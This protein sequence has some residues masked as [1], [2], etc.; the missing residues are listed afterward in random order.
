MHQ[1]KF[2]NLQNYYVPCSDCFA[3]EWPTRSNIF[4]CQI[5]FNRYYTSSLTFLYY[6]FNISVIE[7]HFKLLM[8]INICTIHLDVFFLNSLKWCSSLQETCRQSVL[9][10]LTGSYIY[11]QHVQL[12]TI[13]NNFNTS[14]KHN[15][16]ALDLKKCAKTFIAQKHL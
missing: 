12:C 13:F 8:Y 9:Y 2:W 5:L 16:G 10:Y 6:F 1:L 7:C 14:S 4:P 11:A 3:H 15:T